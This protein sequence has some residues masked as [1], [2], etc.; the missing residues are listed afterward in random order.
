MSA[1]KLLLE[2]TPLEEDLLDSMSDRPSSAR[3]TEVELREELGA[4]KSDLEEALSSLLRA[5]L[6][7]HRS[8]PYASAGLYLT[9]KGIE[10]LKASSFSR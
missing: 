5:E 4:S 2:L 10:L 6:I 1:E 8:A 9:K 7:E 3:W